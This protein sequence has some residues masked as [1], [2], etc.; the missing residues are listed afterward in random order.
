VEVLLVSLDF[1]EQLKSRVT[2][3]AEKQG[4]SAKVILLSDDDNNSRI[5]NSPRDGSL[6]TE[7]YVENAIDQLLT[8]EKVENTVTMAIG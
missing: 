1:Y 3:F 6:A 2:P 8:G 5:D 4:L 7:K